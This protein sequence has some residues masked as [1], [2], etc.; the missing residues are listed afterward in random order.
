MQPHWSPV[1]IPRHQKI[2]FKLQAHLGLAVHWETLHHHHISFSTLDV[3]Y[4][5]SV[6]LMSWCS[7][8]P[9]AYGVL[10]FKQDQ[11]G[12]Y[13][14]IRQSQK[15]E[16]HCIWSTYHLLFHLT[17]YHLHPISDARGDKYD[18]KCETATSA[19]FRRLG[20]FEMVEDWWRH[21]WFFHFL[22]MGREC[23]KVEN[24]S[25]LT[26]EKEGTNLERVN[27]KTIGEEKSNQIGF[28]LFSM[29]LGLLT[30]FLNSKLQS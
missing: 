17:F 24:R 11:H 7:W 14:G 15:G 6:F 1:H 8:C 12:K 18:H 16:K 26:F 3:E 22:E 21:F 19:V 27:R 25:S 13:S 28:F 23:G 5:A 4:L 9:P 20:F 29:E 30:G 2:Y 10:N